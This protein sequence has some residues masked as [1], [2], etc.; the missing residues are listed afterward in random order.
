MPFNGSEGEAIPLRTAEAYT[1]KY[2]ENNPGAVLGHFFGKD[3][4]KEIL[5]QE[6]CMGIRFYY[7]EDQGDAKV[8]VLSGADA[9]E[10]DQLGEGRIVADVSLPVPPF[11]GQP[12]VLNGQ[13][14]V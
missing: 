1:A 5:A 8:L 7:G 11:G 9:E 12:N 2:R 3:I 6:G 4:L 13:Q 14:A 10:N